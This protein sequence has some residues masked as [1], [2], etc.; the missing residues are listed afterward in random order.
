VLAQEPLLL[1]LLPLLLPD[2]A[3]LML[4]RRQLA[5]QARRV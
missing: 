4:Q 1:L 3:H 5:Q 2:P